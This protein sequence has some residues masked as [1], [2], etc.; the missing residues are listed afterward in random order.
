MNARVISSLCI[1]LLRAAAL[2]A[3]AGVLLTSPA[4]AYSGTITFNGKVT[5]QTC[6][7]NGNSAVPVDF[8]VALPTVSASTLKTPGSTAG[9]TMFTLQLSA[10][11]PTSGN[12]Q[13]YFESGPTTDT[14]TGNLIL[15]NIS[16]SADNV[17]IALLN[18][19]GTPIKAGFAPGSQGTNPVSID[20]TGNATLTYGAQ[21]VA[22]KGAAQGGTATTR[23][24]YTLVYP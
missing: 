14:T 8:T 4:H 20:A 12:V 24:V 15:D 9:R 11:T 2:L 22:V 18:A 6:S 21:Y 16:G 1:S 13:A 17:Q 5:A 3:G 10:C 7:I 23:V 19:D